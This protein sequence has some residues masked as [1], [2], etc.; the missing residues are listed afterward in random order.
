MLLFRFGSIF[1]K[2]KL[3]KGS[4]IACCQEEVLLNRDAE[5]FCCSHSLVLSERPGKLRN[6]AQNGNFRS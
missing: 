4:G 5:R 1:F 2:S 3:G 6:L